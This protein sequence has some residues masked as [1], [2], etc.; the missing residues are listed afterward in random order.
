MNRVEQ[1]QREMAASAASN[2]AVLRHLEKQVESNQQLQ[3][4]A[5]QLGQQL[6]TLHQQAAQWKMAVELLNQEKIH[7]KQT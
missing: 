1:T 3:A 2:R 5:T 7:L 6:E 4:E